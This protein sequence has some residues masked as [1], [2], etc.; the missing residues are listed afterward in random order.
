MGVKSVENA[1]VALRRKLVRGFEQAHGLSCFEV[2]NEIQLLSDW[3]VLDIPRT[4]LNRVHVHFVYLLAMMPFCAYFRAPAIAFS[5][6]DLYSRKTLHREGLLHLRGV[7]QARAMMVGMDD[8][9]R[10][11]SGGQIALGNPIGPLGNYAIHRLLHGAFAEYGRYRVSCHLEMSAFQRWCHNCY[12]CAQAYLFFMAAGEAPEAAGFEASML[13]EEKSP[14]FDL[15]K[16][17]HH[18]K[19]AAR[20][21]MALQ[22]ALAFS[23]LLRKG[24]DA[25][26]IRRFA[27]S[28]GPVSQRRE[29]KMR[30]QVFRL[31]ARP[32]RGRMDQAAA[33]FYRRRL[34]RM[35][36]A[37]R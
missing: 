37:A 10:G 31:Q 33:A 11:L 20:R 16:A 21:F 17:P 35:S 13:E 19:D 12:R 28:H 34:Q 22:E 15:F 23:M 2:E 3:Q 1:R 14:L 24:G 36:R 29:N 26:L 7:M 32:G 30:R 5:N 8:L 27:E 6:E 25:P 18:R 9:L 4:E